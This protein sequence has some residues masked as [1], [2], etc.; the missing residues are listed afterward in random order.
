MEVIALPLPVAKCPQVLVWSGVD[1]CVAAGTSDIHGLH[2]C[3]YHGEDHLCFWKG[4][5]KGIHGNGIGVIMN[6][7]YEVAKTVR[8]PDSMATVDLHE[9]RL[10]SKETALVTT[11]FPRLHG[12]IWVLDSIFREVDLK[13]GRVLFEWSALDHVDLFESHTPRGSYGALGDGLHNY[14]AWDYFHIN[15][16]DK[17]EAGD[18]LISSRHTDCILKVSGVDGSV[19]WRLNGDRSS[20]TITGFT[21]RRQHHARFLQEATNHT[22]ISLFDNDN[23]GFTQKGPAS[24]GIIVEID[25]VSNVA[26]KLLQLDGPTPTGLVTESMGS[27]SI[28]PDENIFVSW[29]ADSAMAEYLPDGTPVWYAH[30]GWQSRNYRAYKANWVGQPLQPPALW[31]FARSL[32][33]PA[34]SYVS[35]NGATEVRRW[36]FYASGSEKGPYE[37][38]GSIEK[39]DFETKFEHTLYWPW[40]FTE[41][42]SVGNESLRNSTAIGTFVSDANVTDDCELSDCSSSD[43]Q[44]NSFQAQ[45]REHAV[46]TP[47]GSQGVFS[48]DPAAYH[49]LRSLWRYLEHFMAG[50]GML[51]LVAAGSWFLC[52]PLKISVRYHR[53]NNSYI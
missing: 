47:E 23:D 2:V 17:N 37:V 19:I 51:A 28:L 36:R 12:P 24:T 26:N 52:K 10:T 38:V 11:Y 1:D 25:H 7:H 30:V 34:V 9:F 27:V 8:I 16:V 41:A 21:F 15:S 29:G 20:F 18:Y 45:N 53:L 4:R 31:T 40:T 48:P 42:L 3:Q 50:L 46:A 32:D 49:G 13:D 22:V 14:N 5:Q 44:S 6:K 39:K 43:H 33:S 35:W